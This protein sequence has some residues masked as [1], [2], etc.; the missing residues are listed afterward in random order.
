MYRFCKGKGIDFTEIP[1]TR[2]F[3]PDVD[4]MLDMADSSYVV[5][6]PNNPTGDTAKKDT[7]K[8]CLKLGEQL[9]WTRL[10]VSLPGGATQIL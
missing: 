7:V 8:D 10:M 5:C 6:S 1:M 2:L 4:R 3:Q 9:S